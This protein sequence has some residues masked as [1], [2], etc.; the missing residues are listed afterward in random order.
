MG[1]YVPQQEHGGQKTVFGGCSILQLCGS[2][3]E[4]G[5]IGLAA[6]AFIYGSRC[7]SPDKL[8]LEDK[9]NRHKDFGLFYLCSQQLVMLIP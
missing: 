5:S 8:F 4:F 1:V 7:L 3:V 6:G 2:W 9:I